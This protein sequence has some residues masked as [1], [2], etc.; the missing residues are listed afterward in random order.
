M[1]HGGGVRRVLIRGHL[2]RRISMSFNL[3]KLFFSSLSPE[4]TA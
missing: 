2:K 1:E 4:L 3:P